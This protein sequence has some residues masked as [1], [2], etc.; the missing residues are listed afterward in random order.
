MMDSTMRPILAHHLAELSLEHAPFA[1]AC[2]AELV[3]FSSIGF[4]SGCH[5][6]GG[7]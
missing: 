3:A 6:V 5:G 1:G 7:K 2:L 4:Y